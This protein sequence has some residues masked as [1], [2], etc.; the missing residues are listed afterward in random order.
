MAT[1][2]SC[3]STAPATR[4][5]RARRARDAGLH[6]RGRKRRVER[7]A[8]AAR[9]GGRV[10]SGPCHFFLLG[11][12]HRELIV[13]GPSASATLE[14]E[15]A[16]EAGEILVS[17]RTAEAL[18]DGFVGEPRDGAFL[19]RPDALPRAA[20]RR[21][22]SRAAA[23]DLAELV[24]ASLRVP[25]ETGAI[26][27]EHRQVTAAF[28]KFS[29]TDTLVEDARR[30]AARLGEL[31]EVVSSE[32]HERSIT[33]LESDIDRDGGKLYLVAG[34]PASSGDDEERMLHAMRAIVDAGVGPPIARRRQPRRVLAGPI[35]RRAGAPTR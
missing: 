19:S 35:G 32:A 25:I 22:T 11:R 14:L 29:G 15:D 12:H 31:A 9:D 18:P 6:R 20:R 28:I 24:P 4:S 17:A 23:G 1:R 33:W 27:A 2:C 3:S 13:C 5:A 26:E 30:S 34:A 16:A 10:V 8:G 7:R 21:P